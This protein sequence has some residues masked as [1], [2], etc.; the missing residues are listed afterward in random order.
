MPF[1]ADFRRSRNTILASQTG[2]AASQPPTMQMAAQ[3]RQQGCPS[4]GREKRAPADLP[5]STWLV[6]GD[7]SALTCHIPQPNFVSSKM[8]CATMS[9]DNRLFPA[10][11]VLAGISG[12]ASPRCSP[13]YLASVVPCETKGRPPL[14]C[15]PISYSG[16]LGISQP[17]ATWRML[18]AHLALVTWVDGLETR[19]RD[20]RRG[21]EA[22]CQ[23]HRKGAKSGGVF[24]QPSI[25]PFDI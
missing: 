24:V 2:R 1:K 18:Y 16:V 11:C 20:R 9:S 8:L 19:H 25:F 13:I 10:H 5:S 14:L 17:L 6:D 15:N 3:A 7:T 21:I 4:A 12:G 23:G 22:W